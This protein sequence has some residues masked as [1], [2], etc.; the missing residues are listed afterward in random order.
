MVCGVP[1]VCRCRV[2]PVRSLSTFLVHKPHAQFDFA[3]SSKQHVFGS[4]YLWWTF[5][6]IFPKLMW[7]SI[8]QCWAADNHGICR[9]V[10]GVPNL[11]QLRSILIEAPGGIFSTQN[12]SI[13]HTSVN[14]MSLTVHICYVSYHSPEIKS[15]IVQLR[16]CFPTI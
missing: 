1:N 12:S 10:C 2:I 9:M 6:I 3:G 4:S 14:S 8:S 15:I 5:H 11:C 16:C 13:A 7:A